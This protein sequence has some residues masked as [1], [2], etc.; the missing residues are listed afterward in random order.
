M[1]DKAERVDILMR[2]NEA[3]CWWGQLSPTAVFQPSRF[4]VEE[5]TEEG[6]MA[7][8]KAGTCLLS[9]RLDPSTPPAR[10]QPGETRIAP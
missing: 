10:T 7:G 4:V 5:A 1:R 2:F 3:V 8:P 6:G 9:P